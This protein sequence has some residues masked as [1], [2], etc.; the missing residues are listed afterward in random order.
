MS[1]TLPFRS[2]IEAAFVGYGIDE[3]RHTLF[4]NVCPHCDDVDSLRVWCGLFGTEWRNKI[5]TRHYQASEARIHGEI[6]ENPA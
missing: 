6:V 5:C 2:A 4:V 1:R 3:R